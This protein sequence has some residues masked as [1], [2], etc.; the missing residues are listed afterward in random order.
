VL[1][2]LL[3]L[4]AAATPT[5]A[6]AH[7][8]F[9]APTS[10]V[11]ADGRVLGPEGIRF[12]L[13]PGLLYSTRVEKDR[14]AWTARDADDTTAVV[15]DAFLSDTQLPC[16]DE[17]EGVELEAFTTAGGL[18]ACIGSAQ[19]GDPPRVFAVALVKRGKVLLAVSALA[20]DRVARDLARFVADSVDVPVAPEKDALA[21]V[22]RPGVE[23]RLIGCFRHEHLVR[24]APGVT[25]SFE[26]CFEDDFTFTQVSG[27]KGLG[28]A[29]TPIQKAGTWGY[30]RGNLHLEFD[31][32]SAENDET[33]FEG[34]DLVLDGALWRR[35]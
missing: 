22:E 34:D 32:E 2:F 8:L 26:R 20:R 29:S 31:D 15:V 33:G 13:P 6:S 12:H 5:S 7:P 4:A 19:R 17:V 18:R 35:L 11:S 28:H 9:S 14:R 1:A 25:M 24:G 21:H 27:A 30:A 16:R 10:S 23:P 3:L